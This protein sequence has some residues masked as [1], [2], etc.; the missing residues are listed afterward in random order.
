MSNLNPWMQQPYGMGVQQY[1][2]QRPMM[3][4]YGS[5]L[6]GAPS[7]PRQL[8]RVSGMEGARAFQMVPNEVVALFDEGD[9]VLYVKSTDG[10]GFPTIRRFRFVEESDAPAQ[11]QPSSNEFVTRAE[12]EELKGWMMANG[13]QPVR[14]QQSQIRV[15]ADGA[16]TE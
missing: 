6:Y 5:A 7:A 12:F 16:D 9:D 13:K 15:A 4:Q 8:I 1:P 2:Q 10:A 14:A 11:S 3:Q